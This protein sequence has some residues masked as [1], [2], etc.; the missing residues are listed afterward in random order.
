MVGPIE[1]A[2]H[3]VDTL[4]ATWEGF[5]Q[6]LETFVKFGT[7]SIV[8]AVNTHAPSQA[9]SSAVTKVLGIVYVLASLLPGFVAVYFGAKQL[10]DLTRTES[11]IVA[12]VFRVGK[13]AFS[14]LFLGRPGPWETY[15]TV[16][17]GPLTF[18]DAIG[19]LV[20]TSPSDAFTVGATFA[21]FFG[22]SWAMFYGINFLLYE[23]SLML[24][25]QPLWKE[26]SAKAHAF[27]FTL[28]WVFFL[29]MQSAG[30]AFISTLFIIAAILLR[31]SEFQ[32]KRRKKQASRIADG[33]S[34][35]LKG[36]SQTNG[37]EQ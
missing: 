3:A 14:V 13:T 17:Y 34:S 26:T 35:R 27:T 31:R 37:G 28:V 5:A 1:T 33:V 18:L 15:N 19:K 30:S 32:M 25:S 22:F 11:L 12:S 29:T 23:A 9:K 8:E 7:K 2:V 16:A 4:G 6:I 10:F 20:K 36:S 24:R 21:L